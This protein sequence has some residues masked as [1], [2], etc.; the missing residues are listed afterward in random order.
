[1]TSKQQQATKNSAEAELAEEE[2]HRLVGKLDADPH[3]ALQVGKHNTMGRAAARGLV[4]DSEQRAAIAAEVSKMNINCDSKQPS[5]TWLEYLRQK[6]RGN[7]PEVPASYLRQ[8]NEALLGKRPPPGLFG[9]RKYPVKRAGDCCVDKIVYG[10]DVDFKTCAVDSA[11]REEHEMMHF[12]DRA[13]IR[14]DHTQMRGPAAMFQLPGGWSK[15][16]PGESPRKVEPAGRWS[17][18]DPGFQMNGT[19]GGTVV[20]SLSMELGMGLDHN[21]FAAPTYPLMN[22]QEIPQPGRSEVGYIITHGDEASMYNG[23]VAGMQ[24][25]PGYVRDRFAGRA[26]V[27]TWGRSHDRDQFDFTKKRYFVDEEGNRQEGNLKAASDPEMAG[28]AKCLTSEGQSGER[29]VEVSDQREQVRRTIQQM[30]YNNRHNHQH[31]V[32]ILPDDCYNAKYLGRAGRGSWESP[33]EKWPHDVVGAIKT[34]G[35]HEGK[36]SFWSA[37]TSDV[38]AEDLK[39]CSRR[40][41]G[42]ILTT[43]GEESDEAKV[44]RFRALGSAGKCSSDIHLDDHYERRHHDE[45]PAY[46]SRPHFLKYDNSLVPRA[47]T[48]RE[49]RDSARRRGRSASA[50]RGGRSRSASVNSR[51]SDRSRMLRRSASERPRSTSQRIRSVSVKRVGAAI[52][53]WEGSPQMATPRPKYEPAFASMLPRYTNDKNAGERS[54]QRCLQGY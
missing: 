45:N 1:M 48:R 21:V 40:L 36:K 30:D 10:R 14:S 35:Q 6:Q 20:P 25:Y 8:G 34:Y 3:I 42:R 31:E 43:Q 23:R 16:F 18:P 54:L 17:G 41:P 2:L 37:K 47:D 46:R 44:K 32:T 39:A 50:R 13:G 26:G 4:L 15:A 49:Y 51:G 29:V 52:A 24:K 19:P 38:S 12:R 33:G 53:G 22:E 28:Q 27:P 7:Q 5:P 11:Q 9:K